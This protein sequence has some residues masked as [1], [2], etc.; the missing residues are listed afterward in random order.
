M[1]HRDLIALRKSDPAFRVTTA[2]DGAVLGDAAFVLRFFVP[3]SGDR[4]LVVNLG[5]D[6]HLNPAPEPLLAPPAVGMKWHPVWSSE[7][8]KYGGQGTA[9]LDTDDNWMIPG[10]AAVVLSARAVHRPGDSGVMPIPG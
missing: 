5:A 6:L 9:P 2:F 1:L 10:E 7:D 3:A 8:P 4:L